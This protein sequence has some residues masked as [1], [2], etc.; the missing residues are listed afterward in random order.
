MEPEEN[1]KKNNQASVLNYYFTSS[2]DSLAVI[3]N[4][5]NNFGPNGCVYQEIL[6]KFRKNQKN[7]NL[8]LI[9]HYIRKL[10]KM[11]LVSL[12][13]KKKSNNFVKLVKS[14]FYKKR[15][16]EFKD[17]QAT[18]IAKR[19]F[20][21]FREISPPKLVQNLKETNDYRPQMSYEDNVIKGFYQKPGKGLLMRDLYDQ[22]VSQTRRKSLNRTIDRL[23]SAKILRR[24]AL[25]NG[26]NYFFEYF[27]KYIPEICDNLPQKETEVD[28]MQKPEEDKQLQEEKRPLEDQILLNLD[29]L[30]EVCTVAQQSIKNNQLCPFTLSLE[31]PWISTN[32]NWTSDQLFQKLTETRKTRGRR[33]EDLL[34]AQIISKREGNQPKVLKRKSKRR[35]TEFRVT[36]VKQI[37]NYI[38]EKNKILSLTDIR[39]E[40]L[41]Q[42]EKEFGFKIDKKT[43]RNLIIQL[44]GV[45]LLKTKKIKLTTENKEKYLYQ[46]QIKWFVM[47]NTLDVDWDKIDVE[48]LVGIK[49]E[50]SDKG[51]YLVFLWL[52]IVMRF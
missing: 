15:K 11:G 41:T 52:L 20:T 38:Y 43:V 13:T 46:E 49:Q 2:Q 14:K 16:L 24:K 42:Y 37:L 12:H 47:N 48:E 18:T 10:L 33:D 26:K 25:R 50:Q 32:K 7:V 44:D 8:F 5:I 40:F 3:F 39:K 1:E 45:D 19:S 34:L 21:S 22:L 17:S 29:A 9:S 27:P 28:I 31:I 4:I 30:K 36:R 51:I 6:K 23:I 35:I